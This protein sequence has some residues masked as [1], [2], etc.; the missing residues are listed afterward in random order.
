M[1]L[2]T[3]IC[4]QLQLAGGVKVNNIH[5]KCHDHTN[6]IIVFITHENTHAGVFPM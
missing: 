5:V 4:G 3:F 2:T 1:A 6:Y